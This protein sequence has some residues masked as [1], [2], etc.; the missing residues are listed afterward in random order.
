VPRVT[1]AL[2]SI[3]VAIRSLELRLLAGS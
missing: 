3:H 1:H 2:A